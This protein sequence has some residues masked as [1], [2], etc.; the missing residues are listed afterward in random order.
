MGNRNEKFL[1]FRKFK[2]THF[3]DVFMAKILGLD[4][5][6]NSIGWAVVEKDET[7]F[8]LI[9]KGVRIFNE[10]AKT[11][12]GIES[13]RAAE[14]T[15]YRNARKL[16]FCRKYETLKVLANNGMCALSSDE[17]EEWRKA[18]FKNYPLN[19]GFL[20][21][22]RTN[23]DN[24]NNP[25]ALR[26]KTSKQKISLFELG[27][28]LYHIAQ[29]RGFLSNRLDQSAEGIFEEHC[30]QIQNKIEDLTSTEDI[31]SELKDHIQNVGILDDTI[32]DG[33]C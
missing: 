16:K 32:K 20:K 15:G 27:R 31:L 30:P 13:S 6:T 10:G 25:C 33:F 4:L 7:E 19:P 21:W 29:R 5:G 2:A 9:N 18:G 14:R 22:L 23:E 28:A 8:S 1:L 3:K 17:V 12:K 26:D 11:E 24:H